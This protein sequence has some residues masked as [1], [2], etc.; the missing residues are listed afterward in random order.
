MNY[1]STVRQKSTSKITSVGWFTQ[2]PYWTLFYYKKILIFPSLKR[3]SGQKTS[4]ATI[5][6]Q[7]FATLYLKIFSIRVG[8][9][10]TSLTYAQMW[11]FLQTE[12]TCC[13][14]MWKY[15]GKLS[16]PA[17][18]FFPGKNEQKWPGG[19]QWAVTFYLPSQCFPSIPPPPHP[20][21]PSLFSLCY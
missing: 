18:E 1:E 11:T 6:F 3:R 10:E 17:G 12:E 9:P 15:C 14:K 16:E 5:P 13:D 2:C 20:P 4:R 7:N 8:G 19:W 21:T